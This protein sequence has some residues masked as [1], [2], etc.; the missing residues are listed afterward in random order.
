MLRRAW[1]AVRRRMLLPLLQQQGA[2]GG[3]DTRDKNM[4]HLCVR[5]PGSPVRKVRVES[6][7][8]AR[9][10][11]WQATQMPSSRRGTAVASNNVHFVG[12]QGWL[13]D[14]VRG[15]IRCGCVGGGGGG[16]GLVGGW[17]VGRVGGWVGRQRG[18]WRM[19]GRGS[20]RR[21]D[22]RYRRR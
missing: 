2:I 17:A 7:V 21:A 8:L 16:A 22:S 10:V 1:K 13:S 15:W 14:R 18:G 19:S 9:G 6:P 5:A 3:H 11:S 4:R 12:R 20:R